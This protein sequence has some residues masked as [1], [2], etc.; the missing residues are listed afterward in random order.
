MTAQPKV[1]FE[2]GTPGG[3]QQPRQAE[4]GGG[5]RGKSKK[6]NQQ[7]QAGARPAYRSP[8]DEIKDKI[9]SVGNTAFKTTNDAVAD[10]AQVHLN[11]PPEV[12][13]ALR[14]GTPPII[15]APARPQPT[16]TGEEKKIDEFDLMEWKLEYGAYM[17]K[18]DKNE[19]AIQ[20]LFPLLLGQCDDYLR[21]R[22]TVRSMAKK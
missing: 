8:I 14:T 15:A 17:K 12:A 6:S 11:V 7:G 16:G 22:I 18:K 20:S 21:G 9:F 3:Q 4:S 2:D 10:Y 19:Q 1:K 13:A 5:N